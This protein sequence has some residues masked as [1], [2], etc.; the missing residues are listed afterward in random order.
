MGFCCDNGCTG[1]VNDFNHISR[2]T[3]TYTNIVHVVL[4]SYIYIHITQFSYPFMLFSVI[5]AYNIYFFRRQIHVLG[6]SSCHV[7]QSHVSDCLGKTGLGLPWGYII[8]FS[9]SLSKMK[10][11]IQR[12]DIIIRSFFPQILTIDTP[13]IAREGEILGV[14]CDSDIWFTSRHCYRCVVC[15]IAIN[16]TALKRHLTV[17]CFHIISRLINQ[18]WHTILG[19]KNFQMSCDTKIFQIM[20]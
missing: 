5:N 16:W 6:S 2:Y 4:S 18:V 19:G 12:G 17:H 7:I 10:K 1:L 11:Q 20:R 9:I 3:I 8:T 13:L 15:N 14:C